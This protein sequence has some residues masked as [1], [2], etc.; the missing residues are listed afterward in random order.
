MQIYINQYHASSRGFWHIQ[1]TPGSS[2]AEPSKSFHPDDRDK[3]RGRYLNKE[4][5]IY[6]YN[7]RHG[8]K[9]GCCEHI[10]TQYLRWFMYCR[11]GCALF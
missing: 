3:E 1:R 10:D 7:A 6:K 11:V 4:E 5:F 2:M 8:N 9:T